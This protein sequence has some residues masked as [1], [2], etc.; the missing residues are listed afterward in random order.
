M[1]AL[2]VHRL[3]ARYRNSDK[4]PIDS[5]YFLALMKMTLLSVSG[6]VGSNHSVQYGCRADDLTFLA[7]VGIVFTQARSSAAH[8]RI[9]SHIWA[10]P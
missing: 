10:F 6:L 2:P 5:K 9:T 1:T 3:L 4:L 7:L 8:I